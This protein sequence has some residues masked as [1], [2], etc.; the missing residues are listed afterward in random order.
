MDSIPN[1][2]RILSVPSHLDLALILDSC[3][4]MLF[5]IHLKKV[6]AGTWNGGPLN[7]KT[8]TAKKHHFF[9]GS[10]RWVFGGCMA[11]IYETIFVLKKL[12]SFRWLDFL[13]MRRQRQKN[14][15]DGEPVEARREEVL[16]NRNANCSPEKTPKTLK[17]VKVQ[18]CRTHLLFL[19]EIKCGS[20]CVQ[21]FAKQKNMF[22]M[23][24]EFV[25]SH[26][27]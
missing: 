3:G 25:F 7:N 13:L 26:G 24:P 9:G 12:D 15:D 5:H 6:T 23:L 21:K 14:F 2:M 18:I 17:Q 8:K 10:S 19:V 16:V 4:W 11:N 27:S 20:A 22:S 1:G